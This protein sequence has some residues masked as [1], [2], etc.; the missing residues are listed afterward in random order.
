MTTHHSQSMEQTLLQLCDQCSTCGA[1]EQC[2]IHVQLMTPKSKPVVNHQLITKGNEGSHLPSLCDCPKG[3]QTTAYCKGSEPLSLGN[4]I[5]C[6]KI[7]SRFL[8]FLVLEAR[9]SSDFST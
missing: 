9:C 2:P 1:S 7:I 6:S 8:V 4:P 3:I 5:L